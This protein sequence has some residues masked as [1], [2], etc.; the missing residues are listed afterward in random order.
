MQYV[1]K[2]KSGGTMPERFEYSADPSL[3][4]LFVIFSKVNC[5][6]KTV[7]SKQLQVNLAK[8]II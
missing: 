3:Y 8:E 4:I 2:M 6:K 5:Y 1:L 7:I